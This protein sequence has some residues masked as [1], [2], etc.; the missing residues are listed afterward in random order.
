VAAALARLAWRKPV[1]WVV[2][3]LPPKIA[4][5]EART[6]VEW[7]TWRLAR[8]PLT[9]WAARSAKTIVSASERVAADVRNA[10]GRESVPVHQAVD[11]THFEDGDRRQGRRLLGLGEEEGPVLS[12]VGQLHSRKAQGLVIDAVP[13]LRDRWP[14][15]KLVLCG[16]G[17]REQAYR[18]QAAR[19]GVADS[20]RFLGYMERTRLAHVYAAADLNLVPYWRDEGCPAVPFEALIAGTPSLVARGSGADELIGRWRAGWIWDHDKP[21]APAIAAA[22]RRQLHERPGAS[23]TVDLDAQTVIGPDGTSYRFE[24]DPFRKEALR[25]GLDEIA[26]TQEYGDAITAFE[27]RRLAEAPWLGA[28]TG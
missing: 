19:L 15:L 9:R 8:G 14:A 16:A 5:S 12:L 6:P 23:M 3:G 2:N 11:P 25:R 27:R 1:V 24:I 26:L 28:V 20:V 18:E 13:E 17:P 7:L 10:Y 22:L 4:W 21:I